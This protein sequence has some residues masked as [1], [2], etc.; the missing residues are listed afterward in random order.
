M[1]SATSRRSALTLYSG[2]TCP[3]SHR[4]RMVLAEKNIAVEIFQVDPDNP[5]EEFINHNPYRTLPTLVDRDLV[6][7]N[8]FIIMEYLDER[9]PHPPLMQ[10][11][12]ASRARVRL[13]LHRIDQDWY[14]ALEEMESE[15]TQR[16][17]KARKILHASVIAS[18][19]LFAQKPFFM[20]DE[21]S[22]IDCVIAPVLWRLPY[23]GIELPAEAHSVA[24]YGSRLFSRRGFKAS[25]TEAE[26]EM[27]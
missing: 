24:E 25:L 5:P 22:L 23:F 27:R 7:Y 15:D 9:F 21:M 13:M 26:R 18:A 14:E 19:P 16:A 11:D 2:S 6:I 1:S 3:F 12:P 4:T 20:N 17:N 8:S 10:A